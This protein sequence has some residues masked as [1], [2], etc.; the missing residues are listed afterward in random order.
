MQRHL[1]ALLWREFGKKCMEMVNL[2][3]TMRHVILYEN[4]HIV[5]FQ[6]KEIQL[7]NLCKVFHWF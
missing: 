3:L 5:Y 7:S 1:K 4:S 6:N 2:L